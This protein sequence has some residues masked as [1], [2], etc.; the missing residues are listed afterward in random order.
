VPQ[1]K[2]DAELAAFL[3]DLRARYLSDVDEVVA[4]RQLD[5]IAREAEAILKQGEPDPEWWRRS[6]RNRFVRR[7]PKP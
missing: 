6:V 3:A 4:A 5:A 2:N 7:H 1:E